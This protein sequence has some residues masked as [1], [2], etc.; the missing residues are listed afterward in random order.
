MIHWLQNLHE[1]WKILVVI[2]ICIAW[3]GIIMFIHVVR[4][5]W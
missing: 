3:V 4:D 5:N 1:P 2:G